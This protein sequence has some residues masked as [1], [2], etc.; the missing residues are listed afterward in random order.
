MKQPMKPWQPSAQSFFARP[1]VARVAAPAA[2]LALSLEMPPRCPPKT[3]PQP[4]RIASATGV[5]QKMGQITKEIR[6]AIGAVRPE[7]IACRWRG[8]LRARYADGH[9]AKNIAREFE[10][11][12]QTA[13]RWLADDGPAPSAANIARASLLFGMEAVRGVLIQDG[14]PQPVTVS[15]LSAKL[16]ELAKMIADMRRE[17]TCRPS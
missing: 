14:A 4:T 12:P 7:D 15:D 9:R 17:A 13:E 5:E 6:A 1:Q 11:A 8:F 10:V 16:D 3:N 2:T